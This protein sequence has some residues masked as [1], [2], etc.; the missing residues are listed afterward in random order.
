MPKIGVAKCL[1]EK[2]HQE[3]IEELLKLIAKKGGKRRGD[4]VIAYEEDI[5]VYAVRMW[6]TRPIPS[7]HWKTLARLSGLAAARIEAIARENF[8]MASTPQ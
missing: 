4:V 6:L 5:S 8:D 1:D 3:G 7:K 2:K